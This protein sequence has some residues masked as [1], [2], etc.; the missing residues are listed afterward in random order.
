MNAKKKLAMV[1]APTLSVIGMT[2]GSVG[3][4]SASDA[5][6]MAYNCKDN[7]VCFYQH[8]NY[9]GSVFVP[10]EL[11]Y[12][13]GVYDFGVRNFVNGTNANDAVSSVKNTTGWKMCVYDRPGYQFFQGAMYP[14][15][16]TNFTGQQW[17][18]LN[19]RISSVSP[20]T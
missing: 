20:C 6:V 14:D 10:D 17:T 11:K 12:Y 19:D 1:L 7:E 4:A 16:N 2:V 3:P 18:Y 9:T 15:T 8:I 5:E 13:S